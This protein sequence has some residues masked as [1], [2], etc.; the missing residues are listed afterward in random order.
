MWWFVTNNENRPGP[1][2][3]LE[4]FA[5][6]EISHGNMFMIQGCG[7]YSLSIGD[8][9]T[10]VY[11]IG[12][13]MI[14][15]DLCASEGEKYWNWYWNKA[16]DKIDNA[17]KNA[18]IFTGKDSLF[19]NLNRAYWAYSQ[20]YD[21]PDPLPAPD[22]TVTSGADQIQV[23]WGYPGTDGRDFKDPDTGI[24]DFFEWRL[25]RKIG[26]FE[27]DDPTDLGAY[28]KYELIGNFDKGTT[29]YIDNSVQRGV[30]YHY[31]VTAVDDGTQNTDEKLESSYWQNRTKL[32]A[33]S[34]KGGLDTSEEVVIVPNPYSVST[35]I[36]N[37]LNWPGAPNEVRFMNLPAYCTLKIYTS[38][39]DLIKTIEHQSGSGDE[40][41][42][43]LR[44]DYNQYPA[45]GVYILVVDDPK[46][47]NKE[48]LPKHIYKF[49]IVR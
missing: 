5:H 34:F 23:S 1:K 45:S 30:K 44:T 11:A 22:I 41:W 33:F 31:C 32:G 8:D 2:W 24:D 21:I 13:G 39:G 10:A 35:G 4:G 9:F 36:E 26:A 47:V 6:N 43:N 15:E 42:T 19:L 25:Y 3:E 16:G 7:P 20:N 37:R 29:S 48:P 38:T 40:A 18:L 12:V 49:V 14:H 46:D 27:I 28:Y 17:G